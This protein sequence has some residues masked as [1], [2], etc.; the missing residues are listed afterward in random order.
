VVLNF[1]TKYLNAKPQVAPMALILSQFNWQFGDAFS[2]PQRSGS[3]SNPRIVYNQGITRKISLKPGAKIL[4]KTN[5]SRELFAV[6]G[7]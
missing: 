2:F 7:I 5:S 4:R 3:A 1:Q 6:A